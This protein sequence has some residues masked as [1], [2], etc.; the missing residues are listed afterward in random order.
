MKTLLLGALL[1]TLA[2][3]QAAP[4]P[5]WTDD[6]AKAAEKAKAEKKN[7][8][9]DFTGSDWCGY[10]MALDKEVFSQA[11]FKTWAKK[12]VVLV[13]VDFPKKKPLSAKLKEQN[14]GLKAKYP[15]GGY[16]TIVITDPDGKVLTTKVGY[17]PGSGAKTYIEALGT[18][19]NAPGAE[20]AK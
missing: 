5:G 15:G 20:S 18:A 9:L 4:P 13:Q 3:A 6:Y 12:N 10:C 17:K 7:L 8:L 2:S 16:P 14:D 19:A 1:I 11:A